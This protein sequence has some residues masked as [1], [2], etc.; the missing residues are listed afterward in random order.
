MITHINA[1]A[2]DDDDGKGSYVGINVGVKLDPNE[3]EHLVS[4]TWN[5]NTDEV[6]V[7]RI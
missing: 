6:S 1:A 2:F 7:E 4:I 5:P 3:E